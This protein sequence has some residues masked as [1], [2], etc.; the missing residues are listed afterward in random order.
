MSPRSGDVDLRQLI[1][2]QPLGALDLRNDLVAASLDA[3]AVDVVAAEQRRQIAAGLAQIDAL[4]AQLVAIEHD[5]GLRLIELQIGV[6]ED[7]QAARERLLHELVGEL[8]QLLRLGRRRDHE[9]DREVAAAGQRRRRQR[10]DA[11]AGNLRQRPHRSPSAAAASV[12]RPLAPR[13]GHHA[14]EA[15]GRET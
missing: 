7:E 3:E 1:G 14:A 4:R 9:V 12:L 15:A 5:L 8:A 2:R 10:D 6:G 13:L 11:D